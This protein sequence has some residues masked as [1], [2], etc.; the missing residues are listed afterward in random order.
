[1]T[2]LDDVAPPHRATIAPLRN[3]R[4]DPTTVLTPGEV[5]RATITPHG[6][7]TLH[8]DWRTGR[9][10]ATA[11]G[12]GAE[13]L[14]AQLPELLGAHDRPVVFTDGHPALVAAQRR[15]PAIPIGAS[16]TLYH[17]VLPVILAQRITSAEAVAQWRRLCLA[18]GEHAPGPHPALRLPPDPERL[19]STPT[20]WFHPLGIERK[21]AEPLVTV[22]RRVAHLDRW[23]GLASADAGRRLQT[24]PGI[25]EWTIGVVLAVTFGEPDAIAVGDYHLKNIVVHALTGAPRGTDDQLVE[26]LEPYRPHRGRVVR[27]LELDGHRAPAFGPRQRILPMHRW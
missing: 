3:G 4:G 24:L 14:L 8:A 16:R 7:G 19:A 6:P 11:W 22:A 17:D 25:G 12:P 1:M 10:R 27:L 2:V 9:V 18:L 21:R 23:S 15:H 5:W 13:W 20:W 26:L